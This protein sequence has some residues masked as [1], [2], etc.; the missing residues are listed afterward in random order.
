MSQQ[1]DLR[2]NVTLSRVFDRLQY[3]LLYRRGRIDVKVRNG[4]ALAGIKCQVLGV[5]HVSGVWVYVHLPVRCSF[6]R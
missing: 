6:A 2:F 3:M 1:S 4:T 5:A